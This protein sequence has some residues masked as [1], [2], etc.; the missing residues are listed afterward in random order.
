MRVISI[1]VNSL[2]FLISVFIH[3]NKQSGLQAHR[4][5]KVLNSL[6]KQKLSLA[7]G[8][9]LADC[10]SPGTNLVN[11]GFLVQ[12]KTPKNDLCA[13]LFSRTERKKPVT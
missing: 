9:G 3:L 11:E 7:P 4:A 10:L 1:E 5:S 13:C 12:D 6:T 8:V 2:N